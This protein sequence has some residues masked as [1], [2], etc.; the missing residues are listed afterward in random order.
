[1]SNNIGYLLGELYIM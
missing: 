1:M